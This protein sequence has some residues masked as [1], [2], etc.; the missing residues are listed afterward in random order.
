MATSNLQ[1]YT[2]SDFLEWHNRKQLVLNPKFQRRSVWT[3]TEN[4]YL[5][6]TIL[7]QLPMPTIYIR[8]QI[9]LK[10]RA[11]IREVVD[12]Q[13][14]LRAIIKFADDKLTLTKRSKN[15]A[16]VNYGSLSDEE[17]QNFLS[18]QVGVGQL[19]NATDEDVLEIFSRLNSSNFKLNAAELRHAEFYGDFKVAA[20]EAAT[21]WSILWDKFGILSFKERVRMLDDS[22]MAEMLG[23]L[24]KGVTDGGQPNIYKLYKEYDS[25][26]DDIFVS[27][28]DLTLRYLVENIDEAIAGPIAKS[29]HFLMLFAA[30]AY[31]LVDIPVGK[32]E[33]HMPIVDPR[34]LSDLSITKDNIIKLGNIIESDEP[35]AD[36]FFEF[37]KA[38]RGST[39]RIASRRVRFPMFY[40]AL[41]PDHL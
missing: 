32:M 7:N 38:S 31:G 27:N 11:A 13:Q 10:T 3:D 4:V 18:Y 25:D 12:G 1:P 9:D 8:T 39:Q 33:E 5:I 15:F 40:R 26:L 35:P 21:R 37:W 28:L 41:L 20:M 14:R 34:A 2:I 30:V 17:K 16:G 6:D 22:F 23:I 24:I 29:P 19:I 36:K